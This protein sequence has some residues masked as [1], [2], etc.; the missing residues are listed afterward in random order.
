ME[1]SARK[2]VVRWLWPGLAAVALAVALL[3]NR[4]AQ[5]QTDFAKI[6]L[7][8]PGAPAATWSEVEWL[9][10]ASGWQT[11]TGWQGS[12]ETLGGSTPL[13]QWT[14]FPENYGQ[15]PF[16]WVVYT[17][18]DG[19]IWGMSDNFNLPEGGGVNLRITVEEGTLP[20]PTATSVVTGTVTATPVV[21]TTATPAATSVVTSTAI[22]TGTVTPGATGT[23]TPTIP[24]TGTE[25]VGDGLMLSTG[26][27]GSNCNFGVIS[28]YLMDA[29]EGSTA[30]VQWLDPSGAWRNVEG[31]QGT[32]S[33]NE[34]GPPLQRW[35][36]YP[37]NFGQGP[38]RWVILQPGGAVWG[39]SPHFDLPDSGQN[40]I[41]FLRR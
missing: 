3:G 27:A 5:A 9:D 38:F 11:V 25:L 7:L 16:R 36:V 41:L 40:Y 23:V 28:A 21:T 37:E 39:V 10:P 22:P 12:V 17:Q 35:T 14:V 34:N 1:K 8:A 30:G 24:V 15:G 2:P 32:A 31:W 4:A 20:I 26:C 13:K 29:P 18:M 6:T 19:A 33:T